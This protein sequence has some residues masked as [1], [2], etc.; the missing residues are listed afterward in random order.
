MNKVL[1]FVLL[2]GVCATVS[3][4]KVQNICPHDTFKYEDLLVN[5]VYKFSHSVTFPP[6]RSYMLNDS[7]V[8]NKS[9]FK[10]P[11]NFLEVLPK[12]KEN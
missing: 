11:A 12:I 9:D 8:C 2:L 10:N 3:S 1:S 7:I 5:A 6:I 4:V